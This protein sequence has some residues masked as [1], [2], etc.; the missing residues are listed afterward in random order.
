MLGPARSLISEAEFLELPE[1]TEKVELIDGE[2]TVS[3]SPSYWHQEVLGRIV[4]AL[5]GWAEH[6]PEPITI[7]Q[8]PL[9]VRFAPGRV[10]QPD[11]F[12]I[13]QRL[14]PESE[15]PIDVIPSLCIEV[16]SRNRAYDRVTKRFI[17]AQAGVAE[18]WT[19]EPAGTVERFTGPG[20]SQSEELT[21]RLRSPLLHGFELDLARLRPT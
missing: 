14:A 18:L 6:Q 8:A 7:G 20:L 10:L 15:G 1:T 21:D 17:Y 19:V 16:L 13:F 11:A 2:I 5:R 9:D 4:T 12:V 3:P